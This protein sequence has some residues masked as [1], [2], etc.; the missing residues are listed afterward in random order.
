MELELET[1]HLSILA[2][3]AIAILYADHLGFQYLTGKRTV[4]NGRITTRLHFIVWIGLVAMIVS[5]ALLAI[6]QWEYLLSTPSFYI[7]MGF[8]LVLIMN[9]FAIGKLSKLTADC[10]FRELPSETQKTLLV[11][12]VLSFMG[13]VGAFIIGYFFL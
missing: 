10:P 3:T 7:K 5:G 6:P 2:L 1:I 4:L 13:W 8:V 12:G 9:S 11:S